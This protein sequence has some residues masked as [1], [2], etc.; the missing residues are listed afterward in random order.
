LSGQ[1]HFEPF[2]DS[3]LLQERQDIEG[4]AA[5]D[6]AGGQTA[7]TLHVRIPDLVAQIRAVN[8][9]PSQGAV[10]HL[11]VELARLQKGLI[12]FQLGQR[13]GDIVHQLLQ[14][15]NLF[16]SE[17]PSPPVFELKEAEGFAVGAERD[18]CHRLI[19]FAVAAVARPRLPVRL[20]GTRQQF[21]RAA[22]PEASMG[23]EERFGRIEPPA[24]DI[25]AH[26]IEGRMTHAVAN[27]FALRVNSAETVLCQDEFLGEPPGFVVGEVFPLPQP[28]PHRFSAGELLKVTYQILHQFP[29]AASLVAET[30]QPDRGFPHILR[31]FAIR[32]VGRK[33]KGGGIS[34]P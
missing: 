19:A 11:A 16:G 13:N 6:I 7:Q 18:Q 26:A 17:A 4:M 9:D 12:A 33:I 20:R 30:E 10:D 21:R 23:R 1:G 34:E 32:H 3:C 24:Q 22:R 2:D 15:G 31:P 28:H 25:A 5:Q 29:G 27:H 14:H 8:D